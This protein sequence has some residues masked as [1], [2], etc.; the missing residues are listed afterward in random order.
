MEGIWSR[1]NPIYEKLRQELKAGT[2]GEIR[3]II[4]HFGYEA[5]A[6]RVK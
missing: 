3:Q 5:K 2:I 1:F 6:E 4:V